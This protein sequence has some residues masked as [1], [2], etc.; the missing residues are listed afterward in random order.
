MCGAGVL[1]K[2]VAARAK[3]IDNLHILGFQSPVAPWIASFNVIL[4]TSEFEGMPNVCLEAVD[5]CNG[6]DQNEAGSHP[7]ER[8]Q[9]EST[10]SYRPA[11]P[12][13]KGH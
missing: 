1:H 2:D 4:L 7:H 6:G 10:T 13:E 12:E 3:D 5:G 9:H 8:A 11:F